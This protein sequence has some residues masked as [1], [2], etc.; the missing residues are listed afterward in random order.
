MKV[1]SITCFCH[2]GDPDFPDHLAA[3]SQIVK[4]S[5]RDLED[6]GW[7]IQS[8][9]LATVPFNQYLNPKQAV[10]QVCELEQL[11]YEHGFEYISIGPARLTDISD[12]Q[13]I[14]EILA[15]TTRIFANAFLSHHHLGISIPS[16]QACAQLIKQAATITS[17]GFTNLRFCAMSRVRPFTPFFPAAYAYG[18]PAFSIAVQAADAAVQIFSNS[19]DLNEARERLINEFD[20]ASA[21]IGKVTTGTACELG[22]PFKGFDFS[23]APVP[24]DWCSLGKAIE[25]LAG[26]SIGRMGT[27]TAAAILAETLERG[28][29]QRAGYNG[30]M[31]PVLEDSTLAARSAD[32]QLSLK[33]LLLFST[34]CGTGLDTVPLPGDITVEAIE[35]LLLD[36]AALSLRHNKPLT[37][38]LMPIPDKK[39]GEPTSFDFEFFANGK[40]LD[41]PAKHLSHLLTKSQWIQIREHGLK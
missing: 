34:V 29:W 2:P 18:Y 3:F 10:D 33:D 12:Y 20:N 11:A 35:S 26:A 24:E 31:L 25:E 38:R 23:L 36:L 40:I 13:L 37:A 21:Q 14:P 17:D 8:V 41:L 28:H 9:R 16:I 39:A 30:L 32:N 19:D 4:Q 27:F 22:I 6:A 15:K 7:E 1:R 5:R